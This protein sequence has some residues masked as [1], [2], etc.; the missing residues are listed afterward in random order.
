[1]RAFDE[2]KSEMMQENPDTGW[3]WIVLGMSGRHILVPTDNAYKSEIVERW[4]GYEEPRLS[5]IS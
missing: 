3:K 2:M 1:M 4:L 5:Y